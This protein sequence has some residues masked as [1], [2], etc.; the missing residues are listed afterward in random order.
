MNVAKKTTTDDYSK[1]MGVAIPLLRVCSPPVAVWKGKGEM[2]FEL[3][4]V[5]EQILGLPLYVGIILLGHSPFYYDDD[6]LWVI[7]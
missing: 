1:Y 3:I 7:R 2:I 6:D 5:C 4:S